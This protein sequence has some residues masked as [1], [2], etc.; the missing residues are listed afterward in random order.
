MMVRAFSAISYVR[1]FT[2]PILTVIER[3]SSLCFWPSNFEY[4]PFSMNVFL[5]CRLI[6]KSVPQT[7]RRHPAGQVVH[8]TMYVCLTLQLSSR[9]NRNSPSFS[10]VFCRHIP[11]TLFMVQSRVTREN[12]RT[13]LV[14]FVPLA[15]I[16]RMIDENS[17]FQ[18]PSRYDNFF[19][20][21]STFSY[22]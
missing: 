17:A 4:N 7:G 10:F 20:L 5:S 12:V 14:A 2:C 16:N 3:S 15:E 1:V 19:F 22:V 9:P 21:K 8:L 13:T 6:C 18:S 11:C